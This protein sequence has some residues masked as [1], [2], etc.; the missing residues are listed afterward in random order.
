MQTTL[1]RSLVLLALCIPF[2]FITAQES[3]L[4]LHANPATKEE[5]N[6]CK[7]GNDL[8]LLLSSD[9]NNPE[10]LKKAF[11]FVNEEDIE[12]VINFALDISNNL[13]AQQ[14]GY[15]KPETVTEYLE[16]LL[17]KALDRT[18]QSSEIYTSMA[19]DRE[20][21]FDEKWHDWLGQ[22][23]YQWALLLYSEV[24]ESI[25]SYNFYIQ[26]HSRPQGYF[27]YGIRSTIEFFA[28][29]NNAYM[30]SKLSNCFPSLETMIETFEEYIDFPTEA[31]IKDQLHDNIVLISQAI[32]HYITSNIQLIPPE[33]MLNYSKDFLKLTFYTQPQ[34]IYN[35][36]SN[37]IQQ[38]FYAQGKM[39]K[40]TEI[41]SEL[42][43]ECLGGIR[44]VIENLRY[45]T[46]SINIE[47]LKLEFYEYQESLQS[48][49][50][51]FAYYAPHTHQGSIPEEEMEVY[52]EYTKE[53]CKF[54]SKVF[55]S[56]FRADA[57]SFRAV[58]R[59]I[60]RF[61]NIPSNNL[62]GYTFYVAYRTYHIDKELALATTEN[63]AVVSERFNALNVNSLVYVPWIY[64]N[65]G[66]FSLAEQ[67][68]DY[69]LI[70]DIRYLLENQSNIGVPEFE[71][72]LGTLSNA[73]TINKEKY[74]ETITEYLPTIL[75]ILDNTDIEEFHYF[76][77]N[78]V[79][80]ETLVQIGSFDKGA[81]L[82]N[83]LH[84]R[85][86]KSKLDE[87]YKEALL[88]SC[89]VILMSAAY[90][91]KDY[92]QFMTCFQKAKKLNLDKVYTS[93]THQIAS[94]INA[95]A[96]SENHTIVKEYS[97]KF[98]DMLHDNVSD[99]L[100]NLQG[101]NRVKF[102]DHLTN[103]A[104]ILFDAYANTDATG[105]EL[106]ST[107][108]Y[109]W[110]LLNKGLLLSA[111]R[112]FDYRLN[113]H[114]DKSVQELYNLYK[115]LSLELDNNYSRQSNPEDLITIQSQ[116]SQIENELIAVLRRDFGNDGRQKQF[117]RWTDVQN[118]LNGHSA[119]IEF[120]KFIREDETDPMYVAL[121]IKKGWDF[122]QV[123]DLCRE[124]ELIKHVSHDR[125]KNLETYNRVASKE[126]YTLTWGKLSNYI[127]P[128]D[129][130]YYA[131]D[132][133]LHQ[134]NLDCLRVADAD[135]KLYAEDIYDLHRLSSTREICYERPTVQYNRA[136][137]FG[138]LDYHMNDS[139]VQSTKEN[140][141]IISYSS[142]TLGSSVSSAVPRTPLPES[143]PM[144]HDIASI[145]ESSGI[146]AEK[147]I[148]KD[149]TEHAF[150]QLSG[151]NAD[152]IH[153]YTHGFYIDGLTDYQ[154]NTEDLPAMMR[155]GLVLSGSD[156][157]NTDSD[158]D[159]LLL[160]REIAD[161]DLTG[162]DIVF[163]SAC[164]TAQGEIAGDGVF[165][166]QRGYKQAGVRTII[167]T[168]WEVEAG[169]SRL[170]VQEFYKALTKPNTTK[171][172]AFKEARAIARQK[173]QHLDW[174]AYIMLDE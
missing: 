74:T 111:T 35:N 59:N 170:L 25:R 153:L 129:T 125:Q 105:K 37:G 106:L 86:K 115:G 11:R 14:Y 134:V 98:I 118:S 138:N 90:E 145:L 31:Y 12:H 69:Y 92:E 61:L 137:L 157:T 84:N 159:G 139:E 39:E 165:G 172:Q 48:Q 174:A 128:Q 103:D 162:V 57:T 88:C 72:M 42:N 5:C 78:L 136:V 54:L 53:T 142:M 167:M 82:V 160:A 34:C 30:K 10:Y 8:E 52:N 21:I 13:K 96:Q 9:I 58:T 116:V 15:V 101:A 130:I 55:I 166:I 6:I 117:Y 7:T 144:I 85:I 132:G 43:E 133:L 119:A 68:I 110:N 164:Q 50:Y 146:K 19:L 94:I 33:L 140:E 2:S 161:L 73:A 3:T 16:P 100:V 120:M 89:E 29:G 76:Y 171:R 91:N 77:Y 155:S 173:Y 28:Y 93:D 109:D 22:N 65:V 56:L 71:I 122:P 150:K 38:L 75:N 66:N 95:A 169:M 44:G 1:F 152:I 121:I 112:L 41:V 114:P 46:F 108:I 49:G 27:Y 143:E 47:T 45:S 97:V 148:G 60:E 26:N 131:V 154:E 23:S 51:E 135:T 113:T 156:K 99:I 149:G 163:L 158:N 126:L 147:R 168:L 123:I 4:F 79:I 141:Q 107:A 80:G 127:E 87:Q 18:I 17:F 20:Y 36:M 102:W 24:V 62:I 124:S 104:Q 151:S 32:I 70:P 67:V 83:S 63:C 64:Y 81:N 40:F